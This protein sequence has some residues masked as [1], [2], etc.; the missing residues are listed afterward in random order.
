MLGSEDAWSIMRSE[1]L[2][3]ATW[4]ERSITLIISCL[5]LRRMPA[6]RDRG[7]SLSMAIGAYEFELECLAFS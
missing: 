1:G 7:A 5:E 2:C 3:E 6:P 4:R